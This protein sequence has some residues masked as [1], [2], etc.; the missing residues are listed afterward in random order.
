MPSRDSHE[1]RHCD[2]ARQA[3]SGWPRWNV[4][5]SN[6]APL[7][8]S[9]SS[10]ATT[11]NQ[12]VPGSAPNSVQHTEPDQHAIAG[13][14][15]RGQEN[16]G[17]RG[18]H[19]DST[20]SIQRSTDAPAP[21]VSPWRL[22]RRHRLRPASRRQVLVH[23]LVAHLRH[24]IE[25]AALGDKLRHI[26]VGIAEIA[27]VPRLRRAGGNAG[28]HPLRLRNVRIVDTV[29]AQRALAHHALVLVELARAIR[30]RPGAQLAADTDVG[31][32]QHDAVLG[33]LVAGA[34][35]TDRDAGG[36]LAVQ[37]GPRKMHGAALGA[38]ARL[39]GVHAI[40]PDAVWMILISVE[41]RQRRGMARGVPLL[42]VH[43]AGVAANTGVQ[44][45][46]EAEF[47]CARRW[48]IGHGV[49]PD[50]L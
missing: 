24:Q 27:K 46:D 33:P 32:D 6:P 10:A 44:V 1:L 19:R 28:R 13:T 3:R 50:T 12:R 41:I 11:P 22:R 17:E 42:A 30:T 7:S 14:R 26:A 29:D 5:A 48:N 23:R 39:V 36:L 40:Q 20:R 37:A 47:L 8:A 35:G 25:P 2:T 31:V 15:R 18:V 49:A 45:D 43:R 34:G 21:V 9:A 38:G 4:D 16:D